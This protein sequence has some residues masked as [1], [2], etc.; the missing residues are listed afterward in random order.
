MKLK[1][2][3][4][5]GFCAIL[6]SSCSENFLSLPSQESLTTSIY[7]KSE[8]DFKSAVDGVYYDLQTWFKGTTNGP[9][10]LHIIGD[11]H[12][13][14][15]RYV[16]NPNMRAFTAR[17]NISDFVP[18]I[19]ANSSYWNNFYTWISDCNQILANIDNV[20]FDDT[21]KANLKGQALFMRAYSYWWL[22]RLYGDAV[23]HLEP[24]TT[25]EQTSLKLSPEAEVK[26]QII[27]DATEAASLLT[28]KAT[29]TAG[30]VTRGSANMLLADV[31]MTYK[32]WAK[33][34]SELKKITGYSLMGSYPDVFS[35]AKKNNSE[36]IFE[37]QY[38]QQ[39][40]QYASS[41]VYGMIPYPSTSAQVKEM[42]GVT[43]P[44]AQT[45][46]EQAVVPTPELIASYES[47]DARYN[48]TIK[49]ATDAN[50]LAVPMCIKFL[51]THSLLAYSDDNLPIYRYA[52]ALLFMAEAINEQGNRIAE[53][54]G[55]LNQVRKR[56]GLANTT[57]A[58]QADLRE[59]ILQE[60]KVELAF[61]GKRWFDL[62]RTGRVQSVISAYG[63]K[64]KADPAKY[65]FPLGWNP[66]P[67]AFTDFRT[68]FE[69]PD[70]EKLY[71]PYID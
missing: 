5:A 25:L 55:Y 15:A 57:A 33:A 52:E 7:F 26:A 49:M 48:A 21:S 62:V 10:T 32:E 51:H 38:S 23:L 27:K 59:A 68:K 14:I 63:A 64:V 18:D 53:A 24:V 60:R 34:E 46:G 65:Y 42:T 67:S 40:T 41:F 69:L 31:Y 12:S 28:D 3:I 39:Q 9:S 61:E 11:T 29:Q 71:N 1:T 45:D 37:I 30:R 16:L 20:S 22:V 56:A 19:T 36:S 4:I 6:F 58:N 8:A 35:P 70:T 66:V 17:E 13:D 2:T 54:Q 44:T 50:G 47:G 43:N